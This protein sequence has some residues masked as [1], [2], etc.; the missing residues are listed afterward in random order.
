MSLK[1]L[2][3]KVTASIGLFSSKDDADTLRDKVFILLTI[4]IGR[5]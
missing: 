2:Q 1:R 5:L 3:E 4:F